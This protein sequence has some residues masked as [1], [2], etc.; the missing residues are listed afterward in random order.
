MGYPSGLRCRVTTARGRATGP[1]EIRG[2]TKAGGGLHPEGTRRCIRRSW[3]NRVSSPISPG[4]SP[5]ETFREVLPAPV[6]RDPCRMRRHLKASDHLR[7]PSALVRG[8]WVG[9]DPVPHRP[10]ALHQ[11][12]RSMGPV[13]AGPQPQITPIPTTRTQP[14]NPRPTSTVAQTRSS[15][16]SDRLPS[17]QC[18]ADPVELKVYSETAFNSARAW[19]I[20]S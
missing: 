2:H 15:G 5:N 7:M 4:G 12:H 16:G 1:V 10:S 3:T 11:S 8:P 20:W 6:L 17:F 19:S 18:C 14:P 9:L 13:P